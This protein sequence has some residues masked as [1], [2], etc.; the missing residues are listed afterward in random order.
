MCP[1]F[2]P[3][4]GVPQQ[5]GDFACLTVDATNVYWGTGLGT[6]NGGGVWKVGLNG[7]NP[8]PRLPSRFTGN[9]QPG[10]LPSCRSGKAAHRSLFRRVTQSRF[11]G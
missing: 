6:A 11:D 8:A 4:A 10:R 7:G 3:D 2:G 9:P 5:V 1:L